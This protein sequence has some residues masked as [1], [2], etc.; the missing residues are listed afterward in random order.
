MWAAIIIFLTLLASATVF[1]GVQIANSPIMVEFGLSPIIFWVLYLA[2]VGAIFYKRSILMGTFLYLVL[3]YMV[4]SVFR[5]NGLFAWGAAL[6]ATIYGRVNVFKIVLKEYELSLNKKPDGSTGINILLISDA[7]IGNTIRKK[8][9]DNILEMANKIPH[10]I[11][12]L[13][14]DMVDEG[15]SAELMDYSAKTFGG[16]N[17][18][19]GV[20]Y[21]IGNH[22]GY[23]PGINEYL[24]NLTQQGVRV[25]RDEAVLLKNALYIIGRDEASKPRKTPEEL[26][27][28]LDLSLPVL[29]LDHQPL[30]LAQNSEKGVSLHLSGH[31]HAGQIFPGNLL[32]AKLNEMGYGHKQIGKMHAIVSSGIGVW[33]FSMRI[34][35]Q[36][37]IVLVKVR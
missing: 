23:M 20:Y 34:G 5:L 19:L 28:D 17:A 9:L 32:V 4:V 21:V 22:E 30:E 11:V 36:S 18:P 10:D 16:F 3:F 27:Q 14:G 26:L 1:L 35:S 13:A 12:V 8:Q 2:S 24:N 29:M 33:G 6:A 25:L 7:H 31:T 15:S 37:E